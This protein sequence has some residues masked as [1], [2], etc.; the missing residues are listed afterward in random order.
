MQNELLV[1]QRHLTPGCSRRCSAALR[2][3]AEPDRYA[4]S[5]RL[6]ERLRLPP[7]DAKLDSTLYRAQSLSLKR[8]H[9]LWKH[10]LPC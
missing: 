5:S 8:N 4:Q 2:N 1:T 10:D 3:A 9:E 6:S 7:F